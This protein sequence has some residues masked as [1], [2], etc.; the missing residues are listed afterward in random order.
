V[1]QDV[2]SILRS[3][4]VYSGR[5]Q[6]AQTLNLV[7]DVCSGQIDAEVFQFGERAVVGEQRSGSAI[8][9]PVDVAICVAVGQG[10]QLWLIDG[11]HGDP[12]CDVG[13]HWIGRPNGLET[14]TQGDDMFETF[15]MH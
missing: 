10:K 13:N 11:D 8:V 1:A 12:E 2:G 9:Q 15:E 5:V 4:I 14:A 7:Q 6:L 3:T